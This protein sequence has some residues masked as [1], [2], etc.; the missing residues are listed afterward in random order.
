MTD[1]DKV[2]ARIVAND[3]AIRAHQDEITRLCELN[4]Q[5]LA[6]YWGREDWWNI[7]GSEV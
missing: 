6:Q 4:V 2:L 5:L 1:R 7:G 3:S